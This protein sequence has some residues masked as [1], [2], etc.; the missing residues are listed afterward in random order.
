MHGHMKRA[1]RVRGK[2]GR[3]GASGVERAEA[4][5]VGANGRAGGS[6]SEHSRD[7]AVY[8]SRSRIVMQLEFK[9]SLWWAGDRH[10]R[11]WVGDRQF[12]WGGLLRPGPGDF[13]LL[14]RFSGPEETGSSL[15]LLRP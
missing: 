13:L 7:P 9:T 3:D 15:G 10:F 5:L 11:L 4:P 6:S 8:N 14:Q 12:R 2:E 1:W